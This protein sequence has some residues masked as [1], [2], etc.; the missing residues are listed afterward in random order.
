M[1]LPYIDMNLPWVY[2]CP[3]SEPPS[4]ESML[5]KTVFQVIRCF[6]IKG[7]LKEK[8]KLW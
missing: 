5:Y 4:R 1:V 6:V 2:M 3:S 7:I 8:A